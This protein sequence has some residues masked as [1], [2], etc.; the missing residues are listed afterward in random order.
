MS[1]SLVLSTGVRTVWRQGWKI[2]YE[3]GIRMIRV[4]RPGIACVM[5]CVGPW[6]VE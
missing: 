1:V 3:P 6:E 5:V 2:W 4:P